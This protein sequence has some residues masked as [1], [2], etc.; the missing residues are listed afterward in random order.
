MPTATGTTT[1]KAT[2]ISITPSNQQTVHPSDVRLH[3]FNHAGRL[4]VGLFT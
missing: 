4:V 2:N 3:P 1:I